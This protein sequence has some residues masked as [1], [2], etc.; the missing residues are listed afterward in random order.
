MAGACDS[1][2]VKDNADCFVDFGELAFGE[3]AHESAQALR[4]Y[5]R[6]LFDK[7]QSGLAADPHLGPEGRGT[8][9]G[10]CRRD[11]PGYRGRRSD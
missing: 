2:Q 9:A 4:V 1:G 11:K 8:C 3:V 7:Y 10:R 5:C 6:D